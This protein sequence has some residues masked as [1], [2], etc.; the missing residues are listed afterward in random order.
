MKE[1]LPYL[2]FLLSLT[3]FIVGR[4]DKKAEK[5]EKILKELQTEQSGAS[6]LP[7]RKT[8]HR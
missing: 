3:V 8:K 7:P 5:K 4:L 1:I 2:S 6:A